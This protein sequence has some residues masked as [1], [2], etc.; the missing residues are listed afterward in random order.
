MNIANQSHPLCKFTYLFVV[1]SYPGFEHTRLTESQPNHT[2]HKQIKLILTRLNQ[3][4]QNQT[5]IKQTKI[6]QTKP[7]SSSLN[8]C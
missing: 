8:Q 2:I 5:K 6:K 3:T 4:Q 7:N 1:M